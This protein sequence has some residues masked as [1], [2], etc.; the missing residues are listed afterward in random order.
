MT[1]GQQA[2][3]RFPKHVSAPGLGLTMAAGGQP[4]VD[5]DQPSVWKTSGRP[6]NN[7]LLLLRGSGHVTQD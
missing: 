3:F 6:L 2:G 5:V 7:A 1:W 4:T